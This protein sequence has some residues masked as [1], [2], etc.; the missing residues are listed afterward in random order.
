V[1][2]P[3]LGAAGFPAAARR[4]RHDRQRAAAAR[5]LEREPAAERIAD[6]VRALDA[7]DIHL[8]GREIDRGGDARAKVAW[9][10]SAAKVPVV[11]P[12][13][14]AVAA[15]E[16]RQDRLPRIGA[17]REPVQ[18]DHGFTGPTEV[19]ECRRATRMTRHGS[20]HDTMTCERS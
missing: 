13:M 17:E 9:E 5:E 16:V 20:F 2:V 18:E 12:R 1:E 19:P 11:G 3:L 7:R 8:G 14:D 4:E 15:D 6:E 10:R